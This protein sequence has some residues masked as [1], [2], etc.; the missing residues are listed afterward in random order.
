MPA[1]PVN[2]L[3]EAFAYAG[4][5]GAEAVV[6]VGGARQVAHP[7]RLGATPPSYRF[8]P[9]ELGEHTDDGFRAD[10]GPDA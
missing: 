5:L 9:P 7:I 8:A 10:E 1:G 4:R 2:A 3:D 6:D